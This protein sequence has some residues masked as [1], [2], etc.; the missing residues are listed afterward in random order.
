M[1][2]NDYTSIIDPCGGDSIW[3]LHS[4]TLYDYKR[5]VEDDE[6]DGDDVRMYL[7]M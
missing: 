1:D 3:P 7:C 2:K 4:D 6:D 5:Q